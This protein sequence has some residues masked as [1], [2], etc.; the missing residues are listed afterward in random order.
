MEKRNIK[1]ENIL[2]KIYKNW[3]NSTIENE[4]F[5][6][7]DVLSM[8]MCIKRTDVT[9][10]LIE[11]YNGTQKEKEEAIKEVLSLFENK[12]N[13]I[14]LTSAYVSTI[15]FPESEYYNPYDTDTWLSIEGK[16]PIPFDRVIERESELLESL[17]FINI[18]DYV[19][20]EFSKAYVYGNTLG[21]QMREAMTELNGIK[22]N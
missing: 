21:K 2:L 13:V 19:Q 9:L 6:V 8:M 1:R 16:S 20:Y 14:I 17:D 10:V 15:E 3:D 11:G 12:D 4:M 18:N 5:M 22:V 7:Q